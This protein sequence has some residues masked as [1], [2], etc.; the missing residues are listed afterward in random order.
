MRW[1]RHSTVDV[2]GSVGHERCHT[3]IGLYGIVYGAIALATHLNRHEQVALD[4][5]IR[6][7]LLSNLA[8]RDR[9]ASSRRKSG[10][11]STY[12]LL[13]AL[14]A[15]YLLVPLVKANEFPGEWNSPTPS[16]Q[17]PVI[18]AW[19]EKYGASSVGFALACLG[20]VLFIIVLSLPLLV[21]VYI[22]RPISVKFGEKKTPPNAAK[23]QMQ[24]I[25]KVEKDK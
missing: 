17:P 3:K 7:D 23:K 4:S 14:L 8:V 6:F 13:P 19:A 5:S 21:Y 1:V 12:H 11:T 9:N 22:V 20:G 2:V 15:L 24:P 25:S 18:Q 10:M 16:A